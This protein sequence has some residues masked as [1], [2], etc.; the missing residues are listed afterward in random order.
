V[1]NTNLAT[2]GLQHKGGGGGHA[3][4]SDSEFQN[5]GS[6]TQ[7]CQTKHLCAQFGKC[8]SGR[9]G[10][11]TQICLTKVQGYMVCQCSTSRKQVGSDGRLEVVGPIL[12]GKSGAEA[13]GEWEAEGEG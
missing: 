5:N 4:E 9:G 8:K 12:G 1:D 6:D 2:V 13:E 7:I 3:K 10:K 11:D